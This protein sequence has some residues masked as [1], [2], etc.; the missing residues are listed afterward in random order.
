MGK[1]DE[2][3]RILVKY[4]AN[5]KEDDELV[6]YEFREILE[7]LKEEE[8]CSQTKYTDLLKGRGNL[9]RLWIN[10]IVAVGTNWVGNGIVSYYLSPILT[11]LG[12]PS[13]KS[14]LQIL[15]G[16]HCWNRGFLVS[17]I[18]RFIANDSN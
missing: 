13:S 2:A 9:H 10:I 18:Q 8:I 17:S 3:R 6:E 7:A 14:Q 4:H 11:S 5:G 1:Q 15:V 12:I 16:M